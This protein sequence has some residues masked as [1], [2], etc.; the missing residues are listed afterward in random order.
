M[1][2]IK[3]DFSAEI[4]DEERFQP[5]FDKIDQWQEYLDQVEKL[6]KEQNITIGC[7]TKISR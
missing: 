4:D 5:M 1:E 7:F 2:T 6:Y 3:L